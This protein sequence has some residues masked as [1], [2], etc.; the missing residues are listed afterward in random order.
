MAR[1][2]LGC[3]ALVLHSHIP[4]VLSHGRWP[5]GSDWLLEVS[6]ETY[7]PLLDMLNELLDEGIPPKLTLGM[8]PVLV[9]QLADESFTYEFP[10]YLRMKAKTALEDKR[11][12]LKLHEEPYVHLA[13][14]WHNYYLG[15]A[16]R[17]KKKYRRSLVQAYA[18]LQDAGHIEIMTSSATHGYSPLLSQDASIEAQVKQGVATYRRHFKRQPLGYWLPECAYRPRYR[19]AP[20]VQPK[21]HTIQPYERKGVEEFL[22]ENGLKYFVVESHLLHGGETRGVYI[23]RFGALQKLW[24]QFVVERP[25]FSTGKT[26][27]QAYLVKSSKNSPAEPAVFVFIRDD[28]TGSQV[29]SRWQGY[30]GDEWYLEFH[31]KHSLGGL[32][33]WRVTG[34]D[35]DLGGKL[36]YEPER[37]FQRAYDHAQHFVWLVKEILRNDQLPAQTGNLPVICAPYDT[38]LFGH[39]WF[40]GILWLKEVLKALHNDPEI[41]LVTCSEYLER[42]PP[43]AE[44]A[45][46]EGS[47]GEGGFHYMWLNQETE[48]TWG[49]VYEAEC[50]MREL[51]SEYC[52]NEE[53]LP[54]LKQAARELLLLQSSDW[55]FSI[56]T[57]TSRDYAEQ[58]LTEHCRAFKKL[59]DIV[60]KKAAG[61]RINDADWNYYK[62]VQER[63]C[64]FPDIDPAWW[65]SP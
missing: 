56:S 14:F 55:Q 3:F 27:Y 42:N 11:S 45:L 10:A 12:F 35:V 21:L 58:R 57:G 6:A 64:I 19:W 5:H 20:P 29:W 26:P 15:A 52:D 4:Y 39:W 17:F 40:E 38:E 16:E 28:A 32:R 22:A 47:W 24:A 36:I 37:A 53:V 59:A 60:R 63:D 1:Q 48:W 13:D 2:P 50:E 33:Y 49:H 18:S 31:K 9:E 34:P 51:V 23:D 41:E 65:K 44:I 46:P 30:P 7:I 61:E 62:M 54:I 25:Q 8:T 43:T